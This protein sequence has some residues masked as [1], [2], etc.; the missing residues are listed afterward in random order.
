M[1]AARNPHLNQI[2]VINDL[3]HPMG[4]ASALAV[5]SARNFAARG[6][7]VAMLAGDTPDPALSEAGVAVTALGQARLLGRAGALV[8]G[9][10]NRAAHRM[11]R[12]WIAA[13]DTPGTVY[14]LHGWSQILSPAVFAALAPVRGRLVISAH[15]FF[16][17]CPNGA[18]TNFATGAVT[19]SGTVQYTEDLYS[20]PTAPD[21]GTFT[22][23][24]TNAS[25]N[26]SFAGSFNFAGLGAYSGPLKGR[27][28]GPTAQEVGASFTATSTAGGVAS[29]SIIGT[30]AALPPP[31]PSPGLLQLT[32]VTHFQDYVAGDHSGPWLVQQSNSFLNTLTLSYDAPSQTY[33]FNSGRYAPTV[34]APANIDAANTNSN[35]TS[36]ALADAVNS[37]V[38]SAKV[39]NPGPANTLLNLTYTSFADITVTSTD[40]LRPSYPAEYYL[41]FGLIT[42]ISAFP[43]RGSASYSGII[44]GS[45][46][47]WVLNPGGYAVTNYNLSGTTGL[48]VNF[49]SSSFT[50][51]M[52]FT[53]TPVSG[54]S[55]TNLG[56]TNFTGTIGRDGVGQQFLS[57]GATSG[58]S[59]NLLGYLFGPT[60]NEY[61]FA[62][63][64]TQGAP[65]TYPS[66]SFQ[67]VS[68]G[69]KN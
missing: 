69:K 46:V 16:L 36:Y 39:F 66:S 20:S 33:T 13:N 53:G 61:G 52:N 2:V 1:S 43:V 38:T 15:D 55:A 27:Y 4:G 44:Y 11:I 57:G 34:L 50:A 17:A 19:G 68:F 29:G 58:Y 21:S 8:D 45:A 6:Y 54:G 51:A 12:R 48:S 56:T 14:H 30:Q 32:G 10:W 49:A 62:F 67:G 60:A 65:N 3:S 37:T 63:T 18:F 23:A 31:P 7:K 64:L 35:F 40:P 28:Y 24:A 59:S 42:P 41:P 26:N 47:N 9:L 22:L 25:A 5:A